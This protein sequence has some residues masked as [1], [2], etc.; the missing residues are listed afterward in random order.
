MDKKALSS[1]KPKAGVVNANAQDLVAVPNQG[2]KPKPVLVNLPGQ[3]VS[4]YD[5]D[6]Q[7]VKNIVRH[8]NQPSQNETRLLAIL[9]RF[10]AVNYEPDFVVPHGLV[11]GSIGIGGSFPDE[12]TSRFFKFGYGILRA[13]NS[14]QEYIA[15]ANLPDGNIPRGSE[16][17]SVGHGSRGVIGGLYSFA[18]AF[19]EDNQLLI[20][21]QTQI[22]GRIPQFL[23]GG[24]G[25]YNGAFGKGYS[26][27]IARPANAERNAVFYS[28]GLIIPDTANSLMFTFP[29]GSNIPP[30]RPGVINWLNLPVASA[31]DVY[32]RSTNY[33][34]RL[35]LGRTSANELLY[36]ISGMP[37]PSGV[38]LGNLVRVEE[39]IPWQTKS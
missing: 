8:A 20:G 27:A 36:G 33:Q 10:D 31:G 16:G 1:L 15:V 3:D 2:V 26:V 28:T 30:R 21:F 13:S 14:R 9:L 38:N 24:D 12:A 32:A 25:V 5:T 35:D 7:L 29:N 6:L 23:A 34:T 19:S 37:I 17:S 4:T 39:Y 18:H 22:L 11:W